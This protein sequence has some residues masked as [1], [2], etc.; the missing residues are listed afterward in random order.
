VTAE[1][2]ARADR[3]ART[4]LIRDAGS[5]A[6]SGWID[7]RPD[8][9]RVIRAGRHI[10][11]TRRS[12]RSSASEVLTEVIAVAHEEGERVTAHRFGEESLHDFVAAGTD[13]IEHSCGLG[14]Q[15]IAAVAAQGIAIVPTLV[16][17]ET[18][19]SGVRWSAEA[20]GSGG[21]H[22][23]MRVVGSAESA[24]LRSPSRSSVRCRTEMAM[25]KRTSGRRSAPDPPPIA[26]PASAGGDS[27]APHDGAT[28]HWEVGRAARKAV[29]RSTL[30]K[31][32][33]PSHR[34]DPVATLQ[35]Q[36]A[37]RMAD[38]VPLRYE[39]MSASAFSFYR[40]AAALMAHD[41]AT[42]PRTGIEVQL[43]GDAH[44]ANF[45]GFATAERSLIF[46]LND[47]D[48]TL[49][50][51]FEWDVQRLVASFEVAGR[52]KGFTD[53][54][55]AALV[56]HASATYCSAM[57][58]FSRMSRL[59]VWYARIQ[60][61]DILNRW[62]G[63]VDAHR[64]ATFR[65]TL[66]KGRAK[67][68]ARAVSR[69]TRVG[70]DG[71]L[72]LISQPPFMVPVGELMGQTEAQVRRLA[73]AVLAEY[74]V[75][76][77]DD[78]QLL[79]SGY[80]PADAARKVVGVGSVGTRCFIV[81]MVA[82]DDS[83]DDLVLQLKQASSS[84]LEAVSAPSRYANHGQRVVEGQRL[85]QASSDAL[86]GWTTIT[87]IDGDTR[88]FY[89]RQMW[90]W[91]TSADL[92]TMDH[93]AMGVYARMCGWT[94][95]RA[96]AR[97]GDR[98]ALAAYLGSGRSFGRAMQEF[99]AS[100]ADQNQRDFEALQEAIADGRVVR[101]HLEQPTTAGVSA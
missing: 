67:T 79:L 49:P 29:P 43:A 14:E 72:A 51:T 41:L 21:S 62:A 30:G 91:K 58:D 96:H 37:D 54:E 26:G 34:P 18:W 4:L 75:T 95:A 1:A 10:A 71:E 82:T 33:E 22:G 45:G 19:C 25:A 55:R 15:T 99:A 11:R 60:A 40:G 74:R 32:S 44:L 87:G 98:R 24:A 90:D 7:A 16:N 57:S 52:H 47:F 5:P 70:Q 88:D 56:E 101:S 76:L 28:E 39:R 61:D 27:V 94:L 59:D 13:G 8:L 46:D 6:D 80:R 3:D 81:L 38:L 78:R 53:A 50:G 64:V 17:I 65:R 77:A 68:S 2:Q 42:R 12:I 85:M 86:L 35:A 48:E 89:V 31:W 9:S 63:E 73:E 36:D 84:V 83:S 100:Y 20:G 97:T 69:Y 93:Q 66:D 92:E 23:L